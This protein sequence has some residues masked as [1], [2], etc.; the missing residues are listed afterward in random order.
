[1]ADVADISSKVREA[2]YERME[3]CISMRIRGYRA[4]SVGCLLHSES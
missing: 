3:P 2:F 1:M 4:R